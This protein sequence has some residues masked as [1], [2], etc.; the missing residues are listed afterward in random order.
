MGNIHGKTQFDRTYR[1]E[2]PWIQKQPNG[3]YQLNYSASVAQG[4]TIYNAGQYDTYD[5]AF[6]KMNRITV[7]IAKHNEEIKPVLEAIR[8]H[9]KKECYELINRS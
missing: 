7:A 5:E 8:L 4:I 1:K 3:K 2:D 9:Q 6:D